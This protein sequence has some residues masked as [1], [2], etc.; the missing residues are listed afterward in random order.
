MDECDHTVC[1]HTVLLKL[2]LVLCFSS[3]NNLKYAGNRK[4]LLKYTCVRN[5]QNSWVLIKAIA[6]KWCS[7]LSYV[8]DTK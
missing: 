2:K 5:F 1:W 3:S 8:V 4:K 6:K 7:L